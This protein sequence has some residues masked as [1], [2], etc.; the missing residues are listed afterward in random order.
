MHHTK[1]TLGAA[2][3]ASL[4][5]AARTLAL[6]AALGLPALAQ[7]QAPFPTGAAAAN[8][9]IDAIATSDAAALPRILGKDWRQLMP[10]DGLDADDVYLFL[11][12]A[13]QS[14]RVD[15]NGT[16]GFLVI[17]NDPWTLPIPL[18]QA[19]DGQWRF[20][21]AGARD[22]IA[23][24]RIGRN[25]RSAM[26]AALAFVDAQR[27]YAAAD[28]N[29]DGVLEYAQRLLSSPG[30]RDG[31]I[32]SASLGDDSPLGAAYVPAKPG[33]S[34]HGYNY[35]I[36]TA[37]GPKAAGG[38]RNYL[39]G[40]R[41]TAG[42]ALIAWPEKYGDTG[43]MS[44]IVNNDGKVFERNLGPRTPQVAAGIQQFN[45]DDTWKPVKP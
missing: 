45:P 31:L 10:T 34:Y 16:R 32:W 38:A 43:V 37:Q 25:E 30:Q 3:T 12:K 2:A 39:I 19:P 42:F 5:Q 15:V 4:Q 36:L 17:G 26:Q 41:M 9:L 35:R 11:E 7:A 13:S 8:A 18:L 24:R 21:P 28:R 14:R 29:G 23:E 33:Q 20:D 27:E 6:V 1:I 40:K 44:F 22:V